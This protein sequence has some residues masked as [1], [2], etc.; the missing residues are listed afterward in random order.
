MEGLERAD[1]ELKETAAFYKVQTKN[2]QQ[3][4]R[5]N[6]FLLGLEPPY[7]VLWILRSIPNAELEQSLL[8]LTIHH[9]ERLVYYLIVLLK[10]GCAIELCCRVA[11]CLVTNHH[12]QVR[13]LLQSSSLWKR[14]VTTKKFYLRTIDLIYNHGDL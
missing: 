14:K 5:P 9:M 13:A 6:P 3:Q 1:L 2:N 11:I 7:Y 4:Q 8:L 10:A 12:Q